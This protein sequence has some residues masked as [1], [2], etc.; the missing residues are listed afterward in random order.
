MLFRSFAYDSSSSKEV[1]FHGTFINLAF[2]VGEVMVA[3]LMWTGIPWRAMCG[4]ICLWSALFFVIETQI[5]EPPKFLLSKD[6]PQEAIANLKY[7]ARVN[8]KELPKN[9]VLKN[10]TAE[11]EKTAATCGD[12]LKL[13][14]EKLTLCRILMS[15]MLFFS[16]GYIYYGIS[17]NIQHYEGNIRSDFSVH[18]NS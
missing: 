15:M 6:R 18:V 17:M 7:M 12:I 3:L 8:G 14:G 16:S 9:L 4:F 10:T 2:A 1:K 11:S 13:L 5:V